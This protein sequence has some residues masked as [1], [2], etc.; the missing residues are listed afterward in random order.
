M[1]LAGLK[2]IDTVI[3]SSA[4]LIK[5]KHHSD[6]KLVDLIASRIDGVISTSSLP[7]NSPKKRILY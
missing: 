2:A 1:R 4:V 7:S 5:S 3:E 6:Q